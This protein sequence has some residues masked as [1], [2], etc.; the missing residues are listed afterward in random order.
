MPPR[1]SSIKYGRYDRAPA[2]WSRH[3]HSYPSSMEP[4]PN[5]ALAEWTFDRCKEEALKYSSQEEFSDVNLI[6]YFVVVKNGW[7]KQLCSHMTL[8]YADREVE[9]DTPLHDEV[10]VTMKEYREYSNDGSKGSEEEINR[11]TSR[12]PKRH[13]TKERC[14]EEAL[15]YSSRFDF[16]RCRGSAYNSALRNRWLP[17]I[18]SHMRPSF[19]TVLAGHWTKAAC[20]EEALKYSSKAEFKRKC[21]GAHNAAQ[22]NGWLVDICKHMR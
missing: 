7:V 3:W 10:K 16:Q 4:D 6:A 13:W 15:K 14:R 20:F 19:H 8:R 12:L 2:P 22:R 18:C 21:G 5:L 11:V 1:W 17:E 9:K